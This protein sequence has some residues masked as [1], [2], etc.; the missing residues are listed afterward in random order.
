MRVRVGMSIRIYKN[1]SMKVD[2]ED[3]LCWRG[4]GMCEGVGR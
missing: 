4:E 3:L 1:E 2:D